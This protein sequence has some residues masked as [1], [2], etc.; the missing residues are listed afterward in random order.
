MVVKWP[1]TKVVIFLCHQST[2]NDLE[3]I[4]EVLDFEKSAQFLTTGA[5]LLT[6]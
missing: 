5:Q 6:T 3:V 4:H 2:Y 1:N